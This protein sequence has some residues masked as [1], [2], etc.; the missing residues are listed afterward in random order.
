[1]DAHVLIHGHVHQHQPLSETRD[2]EK[3]VHP[4]LILFYVLWSKRS[5]TDTDFILPHL[6]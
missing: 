5:K 3:K 6:V 4:L 2:G 1:M